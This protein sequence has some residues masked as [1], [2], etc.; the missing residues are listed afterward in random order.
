MP[1]C[2][3]CSGDSGDIGRAAP[4]VNSSMLPESG[5]HTPVST[6]ISVDFPAPFWPMSACTS[7]ARSV[8]PTP[9]SACTP[10]KAREMSRALSTIAASFMERKSARS[11]LARLDVLFGVFHGENLLLHH[12]AFGDRLAGHDLG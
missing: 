6:L 4:S 8:S 7:P 11:V 9:L 1:S 10:G 5:A 12:D 3:A 2:C